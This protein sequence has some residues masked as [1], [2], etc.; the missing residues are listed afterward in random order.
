MAKWV[1]HTAAGY[2]AAAEA[3]NSRI[4]DIIKQMGDVERQKFLD[5]CQNAKDLAV[6]KA[7]VEFGTLRGTA[8][9]AIKKD[10]E[11]GIVAKIVFPEEYASVQHEHW[12]FNH[13][14]GGQA[15]YLTIGI[16]EAFKEYMASIGGG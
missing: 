3:M 12:E 1:V 8:Y 14:L 11:S 9:L 5:F 10:D 2:R 6:E 16:E 4:Q 15:F 7:P 13:P